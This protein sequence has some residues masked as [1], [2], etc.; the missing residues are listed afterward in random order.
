MDKK[1]LPLLAKICTTVS[2]PFL[3]DIEFEDFGEFI[4]C[5][6]KN[7]KPGLEKGTLGPNGERLWKR[8]SI[9]WPRKRLLKKFR[10]D[11]LGMTERL[12]WKV[13]QDP[14][15]DLEDSDDEENDP[16]K[17]QW[18]INSYMLEICNFS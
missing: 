9:S 5:L 4:A 15:D 10:K 17:F 12:G 13:K 11:V 2:S 6:E 8:F 3:I 14:G 7:Y 1:S 16:K 18:V